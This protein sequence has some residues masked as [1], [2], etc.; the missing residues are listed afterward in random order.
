MLRRAAPQLFNRSVTNCS[1]VRSCPLSN[2]AK[3]PLGRV[4]AAIS[5][6]QDVEHI[7]VLADSPPEVV[8]LTPNP[9]EGLVQVSDVA[10]LAL[11][12]L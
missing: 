10:E 12:T 2:F 7:P 9:H 8:P 6:N 3:K 5:L 1:G 11:T 4:V